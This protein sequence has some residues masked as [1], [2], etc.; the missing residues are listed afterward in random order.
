ML[1][2]NVQETACLSIV[3]SLLIHKISSKHDCDYSIQT[4]FKLNVSHIHYTLHFLQ[5]CQVQVLDTFRYAANEFFFKNS[6]YCLF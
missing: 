5:R 2:K 3:L 4:E 1:N 6:F